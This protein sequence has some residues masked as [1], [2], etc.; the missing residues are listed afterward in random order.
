MSTS[1]EWPLSALPTIIDELSA[2]GQRPDA[3]E[4]LRSIATRNYAHYVSL[5]GG[6]PV[7]QKPDIMVSLLADELRIRLQAHKHSSETKRLPATAFFVPNIRYNMDIPRIQTV[8]D[9]YYERLGQLISLGDVPDIELVK[10]VVLE[11]GVLAFRM[12][13]A[14]PVK[15]VV[16]KLADI[17]ARFNSQD[18]LALLTTLTMALRNISAMRYTEQKTI[19]EDKHQ[20]KAQAMLYLHMAGTNDKRASK[21]A[22]RI[23]GDI[24]PS[25]T[26]KHR[27]N[28][29]VMQAFYEQQL[30]KA[31]R[32]SRW[33]IRMFHHIMGHANVDSVEFQQRIVNQA[34]VQFI[35]HRHFKDLGFFALEKSFIRFVDQPRFAPDYLNVVR[36]RFWALHMFLRKHNYVAKMMLHKRMFRVHKYKLFVLQATSIPCASKMKAQGVSNEVVDAS[37]QGIAEAIDVFMS[38]TPPDLL[39]TERYSVERMIEE[40][41]Q[42]VKVNPGKK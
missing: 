24:P 13:S 5:A 25:L 20:Y 33:L 7:F 38:A 9:K 35:R 17:S 16:C 12:Q 27:K 42:V 15:L 18:A 14:E 19:P 22:A 11:A 32:S 23:F 3:L 26:S 29:L 30:L 4:L 6:L 21:L 41:T 1:A 36:P 40:Q 39:G 2:A 10:T 31:A 34:V 8:I 37:E 28:H